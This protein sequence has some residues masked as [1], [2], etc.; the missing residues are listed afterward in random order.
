M[1]D[2]VPFTP[3][4]TRRRAEAL[5]LELAIGPGA[6][7]PPECDLS[8]D[9]PDHRAL[10]LAWHQRQV[11]VAAE[12]DPQGR[13]SDLGVA[14]QQVVEIAR[15]MS[16]APSV[17]ILD[18]PTSALASREA[19]NLLGLVKG[20]A[21]KGVAIIYV[22]HRLQEVFQVARCIS[23]LRDGRHVGT[24]DGASATPQVIAE[25][26]FGQVLQ[27]GGLRVR[28]RSDKAA[29]VVSH[30]S[31]KDRLF[32]VS[33]SLFEGEILGIAGMMGSGR[34]E[35]LTRESHGSPRQ[36][37]CC[38]AFILHQRVPGFGNNL[39]GCR[40]SDGWRGAGRAVGGCLLACAGGKR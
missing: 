13:V 9:E 24:I 38:C 20:L 18:E 2:D 10:G 26:M 7:W 4:L 3:A 28:R 17:L 31:R 25:M 19:E 22:S 14:Q 8:A 11:D 39:P 5:G 29:L 1:G 36:R 15:A 30:L 35:L 37:R 33:L 34:T 27:K 16:R 23:V 32:D 12:L 6:L 21:Q 40:K